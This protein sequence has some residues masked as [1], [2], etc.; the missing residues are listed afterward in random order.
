MNDL[1]ENLERLAS[2]E[3]L[4]YRNELLVAAKT[5][6]DWSLTHSIH[7]TF[8]G[9]HPL[10]LEHPKHH[11]GLVLWMI[12]PLGHRQRRLGYLG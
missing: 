5:P 1:L 11:S 8:T 9:V 7:I 4:A 12:C 10:R 2:K 6:L 3:V